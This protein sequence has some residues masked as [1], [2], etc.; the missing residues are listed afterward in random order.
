MPSL[1]LGRPVLLRQQAHRLLWEH[2]ST[3]RS[4]Q[5]GLSV[6]FDSESKNRTCPLEFVLKPF[7]GLLR[8]EAASCDI[9]ISVDRSVNGC[10]WGQQTGIRQ[11]KRRRREVEV[12]ANR[13]KQLHSLAPRHDLNAQPTDEE[14]VRTVFGHALPCLS[15]MRKP[16]QQ[17]PFW[18]EHPLSLSNTPSQKLT[19]CRSQN[20]AKPTP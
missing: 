13:L 1:L 19:P 5:L 3:L 10:G 14:S 2:L 16:L 9:D 4:Y 8:C 12:K 7:D 11:R 6:P 15:F 17:W 20:A 18:G